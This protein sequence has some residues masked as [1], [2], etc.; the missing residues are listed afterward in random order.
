MR[1]KIKSVAVIVLSFVLTGTVLAGCGENQ[2]SQQNT[3]KET[4][5][6]TQQNIQQDTQ[7]DVA[8]SISQETQQDTT[9]K[10]EETEAIDK[11]EP[12]AEKYEDNF[13]VDSTAAKEFAEKIKDAVAKKDLEALAELTS[14]PVYVG[15]PNVG[16]VESKEDFLKLGAESVFTDELLKSIEIADIENLQPS[17]AGFSISGG[18]KTNINFGVVDGVLAISGI[19]Y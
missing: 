3:Q 1:K 9:E 4:Q 13:A 6:D 17:M 16:G 10:K 7:K 18:G 5:Q 11:T 14:F 15:L 19:N 2:Q 12:I 8:E